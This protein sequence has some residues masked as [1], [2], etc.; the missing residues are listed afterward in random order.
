[1]IRT[2]IDQNS[3]LKDLSYLLRDV[4]FYMDIPI[5]DLLTKRF[6]EEIETP[7]FPRGIKYYILL[8]KFPTF[9][10]SLNIPKNM[11]YPTTQDNSSE[12]IFESHFNRHLPIISALFKE[13]SQQRTGTS[14]AS[15]ST[16]SYQGLIPTTTFDD[17]PMPTNSRRRRS[18]T[19]YDDYDYYDIE[20]TEAIP[21]VPTSVNR[22]R[23]MAPPGAQEVSTPYPV[24]D[25]PFSDSFFKINYEEV[26]KK[27]MEKDVLVSR[28]VQQNLHRVCKFLCNM[29]VGNHFFRL[30]SD[31]F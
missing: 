30:L 23:R 19:D 27:A 14:T 20:T 11:T 24:Q 8:E 5:N 12:D 25:Y 21:R 22:K 6:Y 10:Q 18:V 3:C 7:E 17:V 15:T 4:Y 9:L 28:I 31:Q 26:Y 16:P 1:M 13:L 2:I 29:K